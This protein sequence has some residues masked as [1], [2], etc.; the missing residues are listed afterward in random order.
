[1]KPSSE[2]VPGLL[3]IQIQ[4]QAVFTA[5]F[6]VMNYFPSCFKKTVFWHTRFLSHKFIFVRGMEFL[7][8]RYKKTSLEKSPRALH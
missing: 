2:L 8:K 7:I 6:M 1:M 5:D 4:I 3:V